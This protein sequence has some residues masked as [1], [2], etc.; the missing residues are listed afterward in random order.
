MLEHRAEDSL[1]DISVFSE[2]FRFFSSATDPCCQFVESNL[3]FWQQPGL[4]FFWGGVMRPLWPTTQ[5]DTTQ[6]GYWKLP[7]VT[8]KCQLVPSCRNH[9]ADKEIM[10]MEK[11]GKQI[12]LQKSPRISDDEITLNPGRQSSR[13][14]SVEKSISPSIS[15]MLLKHLSGKNPDIY[16]SF[17]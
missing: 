17:S 2:L 6:S 5:L 16:N 10:G 15:W 7:L 8:K 14:Y 13:S 12:L 1:F 11:Q 4:F 3:Q 9:C